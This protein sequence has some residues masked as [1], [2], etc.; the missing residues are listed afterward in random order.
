MWIVYF[1]RFKYILTK[2]NYADH[3]QREM[4]HVDVKSRPVYFYVSREREFSKRHKPISFEREIIN[5]GDAMEK[6]RGIF[7]APVSG[8]Y[9][10]AFTGTARIATRRHHHA[11]IIVVMYLHEERER[12]GRRHVAKSYYDAAPSSSGRDVGLAGAV[13]TAGSDNSTDTN[14]LE[15]TTLEPDVTTL[16]PAVSSDNS[17][18]SSATSTVNSTQQEVTTLEPAASSDINSTDNSNQ[19]E[20]TTA[21]NRQFGRHEHDYVRITNSFEVTLKLRKRD[22]IYIE[23]EDIEHESAMENILL[24]GFLLEEKIHTEHFEDHFE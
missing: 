17:T 19:P 18:T 3:H 1:P 15:D 16:E 4:G 21:G 2:N 14:Q 5:Q 24:T 11:K 10:F 13:G 6:H 7:T 23:I 20:A 22:R 8:T 9:F 12:E